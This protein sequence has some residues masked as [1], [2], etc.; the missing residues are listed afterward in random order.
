MLKLYF[1][2]DFKLNIDKSHATTTYAVLQL[3]LLFKHRC[4][5][6]AL[7][8]L[9]LILLPAYSSLWKRTGW[10]ARV[11]SDW[12]DA[13]NDRARIKTWYI[14]LLCDLHVNPGKNTHALTDCVFYSHNQ[15]MLLR[16]I[17]ALNKVHI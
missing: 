12:Y 1:F 3:S 13:T 17:L 8:S 6:S 9:P 16:K 5:Q 11:L 14:Q 15:K 2:Q 7:H 4:R 10:I